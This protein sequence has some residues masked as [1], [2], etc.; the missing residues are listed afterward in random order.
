[1]SSVS[2]WVL[3]IA[4]IICISVLVELIMPEGQMNKYIK[5][6]LSFIIVLVIILPLPKLI[7]KDLNSPIFDYTEIEIQE[8]YLI[9]FNKSKLNALTKMIENDIKE[10][11]Y[12]GVTISI[13]AEFFDEKI[14]YKSV[15]VNLTKLVITE[16][17]KHKDILEIKEEIGDEIEKRITGVEV[18]FEE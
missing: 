6:V 16:E 14:E 3:S 4:G 8:D 9:E 17:A 10:L 2:S 13:K 7:N 5:N 1:M 12:E 15:F 11:G 18:C